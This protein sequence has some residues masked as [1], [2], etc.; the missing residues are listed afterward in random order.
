MLLFSHILWLKTFS[1]LIFEQ[2]VAN[3]RGRKRPRVEC[4]L[5]IRLMHGDVNNGVG[6]STAN[7]VTKE[8]ITQI[9]VSVNFM[10]YFL[11]DDID[12]QSFFLSLQGS[13]IYQNCHCLHFLVVFNL[14]INLICY[15]E[16]YLLEYF[17]RYLGDNFIKCFKEYLIEY[18]TLY[19]VQYLR[20][21]TSNK[22]AS[23]KLRKSKII[24]Q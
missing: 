1:V 16:E 20:S 19:S 9:S 2:P 23:S 8:N 18:L 21:Y 24:T 17:S 15:F 7:K 10:I 3:I 22:L 6:K 12:K 11:I 14:K 5:S 13:F 4:R